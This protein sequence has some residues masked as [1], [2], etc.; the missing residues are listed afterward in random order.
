MPAAVSGAEAEPRGFYVK[1]AWACAAIAFAGFTPTYWAPVARGAF[2]GPPVL[3]LHGLLFSAWT[4]LLIVQARL[5]AQARYER[6]RALGY[7]GIALATAML[8]LGIA[9]TV[10]GIRA[11][12]GRDFGDAVRAFSIVPLTIVLS[13]ALAVAV[14]LANVR[15]PD[16]HMRMMLVATSALLPPAI[17]RVLFLLFAPPGASVGFGNPPPPIAFSLGPSVLAD[18]LL[19]VG[20]VRDW[21]TRGRPHVA[22][23]ASL[24]LLLVSQVARIPFASTAAWHGVTSWLLRLGG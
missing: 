20:I 5:A 7:V 2:T 1:M 16:V 19:V 10:L 15:R 23:V 24:V 4:V 6:H 18:L 3:H 13:F 11:T 8:G 22:Y 14:A 9:V 12:A 21:R 17:A